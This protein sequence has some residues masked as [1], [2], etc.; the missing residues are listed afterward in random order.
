MYTHNCFS[1][2]N[3]RFGSSSLKK[4]GCNLTKMVLDDVV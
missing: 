1:L 3:G 4:M 2:G